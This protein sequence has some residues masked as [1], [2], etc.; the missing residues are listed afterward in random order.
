MNNNYDAKTGAVSSLVSLLIAVLSGLGVGSGGLLVIW[1]TMF[2]GVSPQS[3]RG[4]NLL[5]FVFSASAALV[6]HILR[7][8]LKYR[9]VLFMAIFACLGTLAGSYLGSMISSDHLRKFFGGMLVV[10]GGYTLVSKMMAKFK[11][12]G[13]NRS[14]VK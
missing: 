11:G 13:T 4:M 3:A 5:F 6:F 12:R 8:R 14:P 7:K 1:L 2:E 10:S 9:L